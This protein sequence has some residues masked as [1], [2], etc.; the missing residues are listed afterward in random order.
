MRHRKQNPVIQPSQAH[1]SWR[2]YPWVIPDDP[3]QDH[4]AEPRWDQPTLNDPDPEILKIVVCEATAIRIRSQCLL[5]YCVAL[6]FILTLI[7][8]VNSETWCL[9]A[10]IWHYTRRD[11][12][13]SASVCVLKLQCFMIFRDHHPNI[14][15]LFFLF[16]SLND[17]AVV[18]IESHKWYV[19]Q[20]IHLSNLY[21]GKSPAIR[22]LP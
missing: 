18:T 9:W 20:L 8:R 22:N 12:I 10:S 3:A 7:S 13:P 21:V 4:P 19:L 15:F 5:F 2:P 11:W 1:I 14:C 17:E 16:F 6:L